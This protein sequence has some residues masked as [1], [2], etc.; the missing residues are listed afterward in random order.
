MANNKEIMNFAAETCESVSKQPA[1]L[2]ITNSY[3]KIPL[4]SYNT[5]TNSW[6]S[7]L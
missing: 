5:Y 6:G 1:M 3:K 2:C 4:K 7:G